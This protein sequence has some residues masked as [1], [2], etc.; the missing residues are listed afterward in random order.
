MKKGQISI[1]LLF[2]LIAIFLIANTFVVFFNSTYQSQDRINTK[3]Q[4]DMENDK[5]TNIITQSQMIDDSVYKI[6]LTF[7]KIKYL[8]QNKNQ[9][10]SYPTAKIEDSTLKLSID[11]GNEIIESVRNFSKDSDTSLIFGQDEEK[12]KIVIIHE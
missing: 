7:N 10:Y 4:L 6:E 2:T 3:T 12:G 8:D 11:T 5:I 9:V 1:D